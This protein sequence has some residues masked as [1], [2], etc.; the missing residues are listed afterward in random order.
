MNDRGL[1]LAAMFQCAGLVDDLAYRRPVQESD[2]ECVLRGLFVFDPPEARSV[3]DPACLT[4]GRQVARECLQ[5]SKRLHLIGYLGSMTALQARLHARPATS[6]AL[7]TGLQQL[8]AR[9]QEPSLV[10]LEVLEAMARL[11]SE[12]ISP[13]SPRIMVQGQPQ[14]LRDVRTVATIRSL[15]LAGVRA[16]RLWVQTGGNRWHLVFR[17]KKLL[18]DL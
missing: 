8:W 4:T 3:F 15:L 10:Q 5:Q 11:Y 16:A 6:E 7:R 9:Q 17:R 13:M 14:A 1:A 2:L 18:S 12:H